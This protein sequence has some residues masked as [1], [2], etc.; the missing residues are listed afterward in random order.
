VEAGSEEQAVDRKIAAVRASSL[1]RGETNPRMG[2]RAIDVRRNRRGRWR[3]STGR[4]R[5][6]GRGSRRRPRRPLACLKT[7]S[8][9]RVGGASVATS[10]VLGLAPPR[11]RIAHASA[12]KVSGV[13]GVAPSRPQ[14]GKAHRARPAGGV[15]LEII[16]H[17]KQDINRR[18]A[19]G[20]KD[21]CFWP[22]QFLPLAWR[23]AHRSRD[24]D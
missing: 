9:P 17:Q 11:S 3:P 8:G 16:R 23:S 1:G 7:A 10:P 22:W 21:E 2:W 5:P 18:E 19:F 4:C 12:G 6:G 14:H 20:R 24:T 13:P 15:G